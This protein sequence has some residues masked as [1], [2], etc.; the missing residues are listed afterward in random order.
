M[1]RIRSIYHALQDLRAADPKLGKA[2]IANCNQEILKCI[3]VRA[4]CFTQE[5]LTELL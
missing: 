3:W 2:I 1:K 4:E 5:N